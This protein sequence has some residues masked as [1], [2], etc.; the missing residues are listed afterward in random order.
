MLRLLLC[1]ACVWASAFVVAQGDEPLQFNRDIRPI[2]SAACYRCHGFD[3]KAR[4]ADLRLDVADEAYQERDSGRAVVPGKPD[5]SLV[6]QRVSSTD[7]DLVMPPPDAVR[8]LTD[9]ERKLIKR[10]I[11]QG[12]AYQKHWALEP[13]IKPSLPE[14][15][16]QYA[17]WNANAIDRFLLPRILAGGLKP[18]GEA[19]RATLVRRVAF[20]LTGLPPTLEEVD[21]FVSDTSAD[22][23]EQM[24]DRYLKSPAFGEEMARHWLDVARYGDTHGLHLDNIRDIWGYRDWVVNAFNANQPFDQ[25]TI[26][27]LAGDLLPN[28][29][30]SQL[31]ATGFNRCNVTTSEGGAIADEFLF[32]YAVDRASTTIQTWLG[33]TGGCAV[34][35]DHKYDPLS[36]KEFY[37]FYAFFYSAA[38][39][40]M[41]GNARDTPPYLTLETPEQAAELARLKKVE[42]DVERRCT[43]LA[44]EAA[45][46]VTTAGD[47]NSVAD[48]PIDDVWLDDSL[49]LGS[50]GNNTSRNRELWDERSEL[51]VPLGHRSL[52]MAFGDYYQQ[53]IDGGI[54]PRVIPADG[55]LSFWLR[56][57]EHHPSQAV[58]IEL[59]TSAGQRRF[60]WGKTDLLRRGAFDAT[61][62]NR[63]MG[64]VPAAGKWHKL[65]V[66]TAELNLPAGTFVND[67]LLS[68][69]GGICWIDALGVRGS[70]AA[71]NDP[72]RSLD[73]WW[74][75][76][77]G[78]KIPLVPGEVA[79]ALQA[80]K[81]ADTSEGTLFQMRTQFAKYLASN[82]SSELAAARTAW[83]RERES[84]TRLEQSIPGTLIYKDLPTPRVA[85]VMKRGQYDAPG[86]EVQPA[87][88]A[89]LPPMKL[90]EGQTRATRLDM[91][92]WL[93]APEHP[94]TPRVTVN[95]FWQQVFGIGLVKTSDDFGTQGEAPSHPELLDWLAAEFRA[96]GWNVKQL[97]RLMVTSAAF[98]QK[99]TVSEEA[100]AKDPQNRLLARGP[101]MRLDAE[102]IRD[103]ALAVSGL[104]NSRMGGPG[105][106]GYQ[107]PN[108][109]EPVGYGD[110]NTR[111]YLQDYGPD[112]YRRSLYSFIKRTAPPPFMSNFDAPNREMFCTRRERGNTPLQALQLM[113]DIQHVEAARGLAERILREGGQTAE[114]RIDYAVRLTLARAPHAE[115]AQ[116]L[117]QSLERFVQR[118]AEDAAAA[119]ELLTVGQS[120]SGSTFDSQ[121]LAAYTLLANLILN[122]DETVTRN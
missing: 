65:T 79:Q 86:E 27:Q 24:V 100:L 107:P 33:M 10:W 104:L 32:R 102:Q 46:T 70:A 4:Q 48:G 66:A 77:K 62:N 95:R 106:R 7:P 15:A 109:W 92:R 76:A 73:N 58:M 68:Q 56:I 47:G 98:R 11:E 60:G 42:A 113:N 75:Y 18:Q 41:D 89:F 103:N 120:P 108:I 25:F 12:G 61:G 118:Y 3:A 55:K 112:L 59:N 52:K 99:S 121:E 16:D 81:Q 35:H 94:L 105:F 72:R 6:W 39:P 96:S 67:L 26:E 37:S 23:Y 74:N 64:E 91:A 85:H 8:Q 115:E 57:D 44:E 36:T 17:A 14:P 117:A 101:R 19:D 82:V 2:L 1:L 49:P 43:E 119:K 54:V 29:T 110:S 21:Q 69:F 114:Q 40:A 51:E 63:L 34:C 122:L 45:K 53:K 31:V 5:E 83:N 97:M 71:E 50:S 116:L 9:D 20:T 111:Y 22:A 84:R 80:G 90:A 87:T 13:I 78:K 38:D 93:V 88:P 28:P 30:Q